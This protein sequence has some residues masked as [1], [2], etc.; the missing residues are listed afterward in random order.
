[1]HLFCVEHNINYKSLYNSFAIDHIGIKMVHSLKNAVPK[2][3]I[4]WLLYEEGNMF[5]THK[6]PSKV[7]NN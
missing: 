2:L 1:M 4:N 5:M 7:S 3:N 6:L